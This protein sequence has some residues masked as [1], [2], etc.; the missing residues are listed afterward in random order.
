M[1]RKPKEYAEFRVLLLIRNIP[2]FINIF[3]FLDDFF[4]MNKLGVSLLTTKK[5]TDLCNRVLLIQ[6][7]KDQIKITRT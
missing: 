2:H 4:I 6:F 3:F 1:S 5:S 7:V